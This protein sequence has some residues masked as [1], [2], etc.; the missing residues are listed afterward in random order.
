[1][2]FCEK[3]KNLA[4]KV[5]SESEKMAAKKEIEQIKEHIIHD[6]A[7][8]N[9]LFA[10]PYLYW[11]ISK[12]GKT[13]GYKVVECKVD[14]KPNEADRY[15]PIKEVTAKS[16]KNL[17]TLEELAEFDHSRTSGTSF[18]YY[19]KHPQDH[20]KIVNKCRVPAAMELIKQRLG[21]SSVKK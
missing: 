13:E 18:I 7:E 20:A 9:P 11:E 10:N 14:S 21:N 17:F 19:G 4:N 6:F 1:M 5:K 15:T 12:N 16:G 2:A 8:N 3:M